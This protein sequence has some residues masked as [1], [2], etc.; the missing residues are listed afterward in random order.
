MSNV[1]MFVR[2]RYIFTNVPKRK[3]INHNKIKRFIKDFYRIYME[4]CSFLIT[5]SSN[6]AHKS[7]FLTLLIHNSKFCATPVRI[8][9]ILQTNFPISNQERPEEIWRKAFCYSQLIIKVWI[10][11]KLFID[12]STLVWIQ[13][14]ILVTQNPYAEVFLNTTKFIPKCL[15]LQL[16]KIYTFIFPVLDPGS[17]VVL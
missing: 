10:S 13:K 15:K 4:Y 11:S 12:P 2:T 16:D 8:A 5:H 1:K 9:E 14:Y 3:Y 17:S 6:F 7:T